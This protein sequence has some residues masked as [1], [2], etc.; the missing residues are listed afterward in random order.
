MD[1][2]LGS[3]KRSVLRIFCVLIPV[4]LLTGCPSWPPVESAQDP[5]GWSDSERTFFYYTTQGSRLIRREWL[6]ALERHDSQERF[7]EDGLKRFGY[8]PGA[9]VGV[10]N[11]D[12]LPIGF[13]VDRQW[14]GMTCAACHTSEV[15]YGGTTLRVDGA[16]AG[17]DMYEF[18][19]K[20][21][22]ALRKAADDDATFLRF[23]QNVLGANNTPANRVVLREDADPEKGIR[24]FSAKFK[25]FV[26]DSTPTA[27]LKWGPARLDAFGMI[28]NRVASIDLNLP[29]NSKR[30]DAPVSYPFLWSSSW[31]DF[32]QWNGA[33]PNDDNGGLLGRIHRLARNVG[34]VL[35][36][37]GTVDLSN[38][39]PY[40]SSAN[41][42]NLILLE[43]KAS[44]LTAPEWP[45]TFGIPDAVRVA[46]GASLYQTQRCVV[47][48]DLVPKNDQ[49]RFVQVKKVPVSVVRTDDAMTTVSASRRADSGILQGRPLH[50][51]PLFPS[52]PIGPNELVT[53]L[54]SHVVIGVMFHGLNPAAAATQL[55]AA[56]FDASSVAR[57][58][59]A[60]PLNG[61]WATGPYLHNG[62][63]RTLYQLLLPEAQR[64]ARFFVGS[65][66]FDPIEVGFANEPGII[67]FEL[68]TTL[69]GNRNT[70]HPFGTG[71][72][73]DDRKSLVEYLKTL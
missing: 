58:Y 30:P 10:Y 27:P 47:C 8:L 65:R 36:V 45:A 42:G 72:S 7:L 14:I 37:F 63:V 28:F 21:D 12:K 38:P 46:S 13:A 67:A 71:M 53:D 34:Q 70:G 66:N 55:P 15:T 62:S 57:N 29:G 40:P 5:Q 68:D 41:L 51:L 31:H 3:A 44:M 54:L 64:Q 11:P 19:A 9:Q 60:R 24:A 49:K 48:H 6:L 61:I 59:K 69:P 56:L 22:L 16:P 2:V 17:A 1:D 73:D 18:L 32:T 25:G 4:F 52:R 35:G 33:V 50:P 39:P 23:A 43:E 26:A 20:L